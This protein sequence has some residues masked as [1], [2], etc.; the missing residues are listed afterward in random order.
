MI[1]RPSP[2]IKRPLR[3]AGLDKTQIS[4]FGRFCLIKRPLRPLAWSSTLIKRPLIKLDKKAIGFDKTA[5][6]LDKVAIRFAS[7][8][9]KGLGLAADKLLIRDNMKSAI[10]SPKLEI[11]PF[12]RFSLKNGH[13]GHWHRLRAAYAAAASKIPPLCVARKLVS[14]SP[15]GQPTAPK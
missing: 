2:L 13:C 10:R 5:A 11:W 8:P 1:K 6:G 14:G 7:L 3:L 15:T 12:V 4:Q 9:K